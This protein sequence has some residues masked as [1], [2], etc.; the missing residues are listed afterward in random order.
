MSRAWGACPQSAYHEAEAE[1]IQGELEALGDGY[2]DDGVV[3]TLLRA[4]VQQERRRAS[5]QERCRG[6]EGSHPRPT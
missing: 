2:A 1:R 6:E 3:R 4:R 5:G